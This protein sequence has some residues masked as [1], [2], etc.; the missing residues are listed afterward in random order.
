[1]PEVINISQREAV[2]LVS[3]CTQFSQ[4]EA[5]LLILV[6]IQLEKNLLL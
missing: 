3:V 6:C 5:V 4:R 1:M 2:L